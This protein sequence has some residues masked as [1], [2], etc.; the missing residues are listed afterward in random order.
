M[1]TIILNDAQMQIYEAIFQKSAHRVFISKSGK[2]YYTKI[3]DSNWTRI[4]EQK[5]KL[6]I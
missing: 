2:Y 6:F 1:Y 5:A 3:D 4:S